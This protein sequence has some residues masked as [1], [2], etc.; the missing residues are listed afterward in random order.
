M[1]K[2]HIEKLLEDDFNQYSQIERWIKDK[3]ITQ[4][5]IGEFLFSYLQQ[6][7]SIVNRREFYKQFSY[8]K[9]L[10]IINEHYS[11]R[12]KHLKNDFYS[13]ILWFLNIDE[14]FN[15]ELLKGK[16]IYFSPD[17]QIGII[18]KLFFLKVSG[19]F[20]LTIEKLEELKRFDLDLY[21]INLNFNTEI[22]I[23]LSTDVVIQA[24]ISYK[25]KQRFCVE[26]ELLKVVLEDLRLDK[27]RRFKLAHYFENCLGRLS[28]EFNWE[29]NGEIFNKTFGETQFYYAITI[30][31]GEHKYIKDRRVD[32][33][34]FVCNPH[35][36]ELKEAVKLLPGRKWNKEYEHWG[37]PSRY[38]DQVIDFAKKYRFF[39]NFD[40]SVYENNTHLADFKRTFKQKK[41]FGE[42]EIP[43]I[44]NGIQ[45]CE[46]RLA[47]KPDN[48]FK[49]E[50][51]WCMGEPCFSKCETIHSTKEWDKYTLLDFCEI[52]GFNTDETNNKGELIP[53][54]Y[55][56]Q[57]IGLINRFNRLLNKLYCRDCDHILHPMETS[58]FAA[59]TVVRF[60][61]TNEKCLNNDIVYLNHCLNGK[62]NN[63]IDSR[64][65]KKCVNG[66]FICDSCGSC[67]SHDMLNRRLNNLILTGGLIHEN[68][69]IAVD[70]KLGHL[71]RGDYFCYK[72]GK[73]MKEEKVDIFYC[74]NC[75]VRYDTTRYK[76]KRLHKY[77]SKKKQL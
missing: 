33:D 29:R 60:H 30:S 15:F 27:T 26:S 50:F 49:K 39:L 64:D 32:H 66:L 22:P 3:V 51:W 35:F 40:G 57:F 10:V 34:S 8:I 16:F 19:K 61:C 52:L 63:I 70:E 23:D 31:A 5:E 1:P 4:E 47:N 42:T 44:P 53:K 46:G 74:P 56:Y 2:S 7:I 58:H 36:E 77:L 9:Y 38:G 18:R 11:E 24:L 41:V 6:Q 45:F 69:K 20:D 43:N 54:G 13:I 21:N 25:E 67:C 14:E 65:S 68:L 76:F 17:E 37:V 48:L 12:I 62:C 28:P 71:E 59:Y 75:N 55:Y 73:D 72:C